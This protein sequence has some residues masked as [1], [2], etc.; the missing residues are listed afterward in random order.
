MP[1]YDTALAAYNQIPHVRVLFDNGAGTAAGS[2]SN[3][4]DP[5]SGFAQDFS[6]LPITGTTARTWYFGPGGTLTDTP[7]LTA[8]TN[9]FTDDAHALPLTDFGSNTGGGGLWGNASQW[10]WSWQQNPTGTAVSYVSSP[11]AANTAV[12]GSGAVYLWVRS[13]TPDVD[14]VATISE[15]RPDGNETFVQNGY[16]RASE[17]KLATTSNN[18]FK[19]PSTTLEPVPTFTAADASPMPSDQFVKVAVPLYYE[20]HAYRAGSRIRVTIAA[21]NGTQPVWSFGQTVPDGTSNVAI[22]FSPTMPSS[23][24]LPIVPGV[25]VPTALPACP[26]LRNEPCRPYQ[27][28]VNHTP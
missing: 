3:P 24:V 28:M 26:S 11:L 1:T 15:V 8:G 10:S 17:R 22:S 2:S 18:I 12:I 9:S 13:S 23:L 19:R 25:A 6:A 21:P 14:L 4:G 7:P 20:G 27:P 5:I 16:I